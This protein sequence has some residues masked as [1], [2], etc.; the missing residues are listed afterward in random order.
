MTMKPRIGFFLER[1]ISIVVSQ[2]A[3][4]FAKPGATILVYHDVVSGATKEDIENDSVSLDEFVRQMRFLRENS[5]KI[6]ALQELI[7]LIR[8]RKKIPRKS[9]VVTFDDGY[10]SSYTNAYPILQKYNIPATVFIT[11]GF[12]GEKKRFPWLE[13]KNNHCR[14]YESMPMNEEEIIQLYTPL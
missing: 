13:G 3:K 6:I 8:T 1:S 9:V 11:T 7:C 12:I 10:R 2:L 5:F 14:S 4:T